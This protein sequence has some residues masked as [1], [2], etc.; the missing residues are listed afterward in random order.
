MQTKKDKPIFIETPEK[1]LLGT[2]AIYD[3]PGNGDTG[4]S[5]V[6][7][8][9]RKIFEIKITRLSA[10]LIATDELFKF[11]TVI[12]AGGSGS[13]QA[14][15][16]GEAGRNNIRVF[17][18]KGGN[19]L[20]ICA[21][22]YLATSG[23]D[24]SLGI[25]NA[26]TISTIEWKRGEGFIEMEI[27]KDGFPILGNFDRPFKCRYANGPLIQP[28]ENKALEPYTTVAYFRSEISENNIAPGVMIHT[29][30]AAYSHF[31]KGKV[32]IISSHPEN[33]PGLENF[34]PRVLSWLKK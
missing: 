4:M 8:N 23:F 7:D 28:T 30:A 33:T 11:D 13:K 15:A 19:Y 20:G 25:I 17:V 29:P 22:A 18:E 24:W 10:D 9:I 26:Q 6:I 34:I 3:G 32:F 14:L 31:G 5:N 1:P 16:I 2:V 12:F 21:G 27:T